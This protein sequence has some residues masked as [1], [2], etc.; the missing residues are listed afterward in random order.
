MT[1]F[2][3]IVCTVLLLSYISSF[4]LQTPLASSPCSLVRPKRS[5]SP[6]PPLT[7]RSVGKSPSLGAPPS[8]PPVSGPLP[9]YATSRQTVLV[10]P[11][12]TTLAPSSSLLEPYVKSLDERRGVVLTSSYQF[13]G[14]YAKW[15]L[16]VK[17][18]MIE[19]VG[20]VVVKEK[21]DGNGNMHSNSNP[22][23][24]S[25]ASA[26]GK[27][28]AQGSE[29]VIRALGMRGDVLIDSI[30]R[31]LIDDF[32]LEEVHS[33]GYSDED[34][35]EGDESVHGV[36]EGVGK[37]IILRQSTLE[38]AKEAGGGEREVFITIEDNVD[39]SS[40]SSSSSFLEEN[41]TRSTPGLMSITR[42]LL[43]TF[44]PPPGSPTP[45][46]EAG[47]TLGLYG[48]MGYDL[49]FQFESSIPLCRPR[50][51]EDRSIVFYIPEEVLVIDQER[52]RSWSTRFEFE[53]RVTRRNTQEYPPTS[54][55][56]QPKHLKTPFKHAH[57]AGTTSQQE[58]TITR[59]TPLGNF[60]SSVL[61]A[62]EKF[63]AGDLFEAVLSQ[64]FSVPLPIGLLPSSLFQRLK[65]RNPSPYGFMI[66]LGK[67]E[68]LIGASPE[69]FVRV[70][71]TSEMPITATGTSDTYGPP[72][73]WRVE[74]CPIS[75]T[76]SRGVDPLGDADG[77]EKLLASE[78]EKS[79]LT[80]CTDVDRND[81]SRLCVPGTVQLLSRRSIELYSKV[82][83]TVDHVVGI[84][85]SEYDGLDA[86]LAHT[87]AVTVTG[88]PKARAMEF[89]EENE[90]S[91]R[92]WYGGAIGFVGFD[93]TVNTGLTLRT[94]RV[95]KGVGEVR[96]GATLLY[97]SDPELEERETE[98]KASAML[99]AL[100]RG[101]DVEPSSR[102]D[103][104]SSPT[105]GGEEI[106]TDEGKDK[107]VLLIDHDDS[108]VHTLG[109][110]MRQT[111][112]DVS[113]IRHGQRVYDH[114]S[115]LMSEGSKP[116]LVLLS[117]GPGIPMDFEMNKMMDFLIESRI[118]AF[119]VCLGLQGM[120]EYWG[121]DL[122][123]L[124][125]PVHGKSSPVY[126]KDTT[127]GKKSILLGIPDSF[128][129]ARY[130]SL[131]GNRDTLPDVLDVICETDDGLVMGIQHKTLPY[132]SVQFHP[133]SILTESNVG[134]RMLQNALRLLYYKDN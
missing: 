122:K 54:M 13:P 70:E 41:R 29:C 91:N 77:I 132:A 18:V 125:V 51:E 90:N 76:V 73:Y 15:S 81:K 31:G 28:R 134:L 20:R 43:S 63:S 10:T 85:R 82:I 61:S 67:E 83:H 27:W 68:Y 128:T 11:I 45:S 33:K 59:D 100:I 124:D 5:V 109:N 123:L 26:R 110:Y 24:N 17:D 57:T 56:T 58:P 131:Y 116:D 119:G 120:V 103:P 104:L 21:E 97:D 98:L 48:A 130:H 121:G 78:K 80:M 118:P 47:K 87:W 52:R 50:S 107:T 69:M 34:S 1:G 8:R 96:A 22:N 105:I 46:T 9:P 115:K 111:G 88:A 25:N 79:E 66:N 2:K 101:E 36:W 127:N 14:R 4:V 55:V 35:N 62:R 89:V 72:P 7:L 84:L 126:R 39:D 106:F 114:I 65:T 74:T 12:T 102:S 86:F 133:E 32:S 53:D 93:G 19:V 108:F 94:V 129:V 112:A 30:I 49:T 16:G 95:K 23:S 40:S 37:R 92:D 71:K 42:S 3:F 113:T 60:A 6:I 64:T 117:P 44:A 99:D 75:G 38:G